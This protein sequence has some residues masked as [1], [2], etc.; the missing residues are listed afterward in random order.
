MCVS[1][2][3][4]SPH[5]FLGTVLVELFIQM[6]ETVDYGSYFGAVLYLR[7]Y[8]V[9]LIQF[10]DVYSQVVAHCVLLI[11]AAWVDHEPSI[12]K[13]TSTSV[14]IACSRA[15]ALLAQL[16]AWFYLCFFL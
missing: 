5:S 7:T 4:P 12:S 15:E 3:H 11:S 9:S 8:T 2:M 16:S 6:S 10:I 14:V 1:T 13:M